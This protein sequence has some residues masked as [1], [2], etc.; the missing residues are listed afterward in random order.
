MRE[1]Y[2]GQRG[3]WRQKV[4]KPFRWVPDKNRELV[5]ER[6][7]SE[8]VGRHRG[9]GRWTY[10]R[11]LGHQ[12]IPASAALLLPGTTRFTW[13]VEEDEH[14]FPQDGHPQPKATRDYLK[15]GRSL[16]QPDP[17]TLR[18][19]KPTKHEVG[20]L[21]GGNSPT[22]SGRAVDG[23]RRSAGQHP[24]VR[25]RPKRHLSQGPAEGMPYQTPIASILHK[26]VTGRPRSA[27]PVARLWRPAQGPHSSPDAAM[28]K[29]IQGRT[30]GTV[31]RE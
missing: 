10:W 24:A 18:S 31:P 2:A 23:H 11:I 12:E 7:G 15:T 27:S 14:F 19:S 1:V 20:R 28:S 22:E 9:G 25:R 21:Q 26:Y 29:L 8:Q 3:A 5:V 17:L 13:H 6:G 30:R 4:R 16:T